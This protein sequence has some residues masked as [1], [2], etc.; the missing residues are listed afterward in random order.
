MPLFS[1]KWGFSLVS[2]TD[3]SRLSFILSFLVR[4]KNQQ[5]H[6]PLLGT[7]LWLNAACQVT[8]PTSA[9]VLG[10]LAD[11]HEWHLPTLRHSG[12][13]VRDMPAMRD[14]WGIHCCWELPRVSFFSMQSEE[15][16]S[17]LEEPWLEFGRPKFRFLLWC[18]LLLGL[19]WHVLLSV[20]SQSECY[21][22][23]ML[24]NIMC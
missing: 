14:V 1:L 13:A 10:R 18:R 24:Q 15:S 2:K 4:E 11:S 17:S 12:R 3:T 22:T 16:W 6:N 20:W 8:E 21:P 7:E 19:T 5:N 9:S 23:E